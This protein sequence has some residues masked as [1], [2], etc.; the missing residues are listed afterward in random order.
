MFDAEC[1]VAEND[2]TQ[3]PLS[4]WVHQLLVAA[5]GTDSGLRAKVA[6]IDK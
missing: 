6:L 5:H 3:M 4:L 2:V 1:G